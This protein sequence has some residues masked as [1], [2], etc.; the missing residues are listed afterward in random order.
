M[1]VSGQ[2]H[3]LDV[4]PPGKKPP[5]LIAWEDPKKYVAVIFFII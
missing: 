2:L 5:E 1:E 3:V 4:L